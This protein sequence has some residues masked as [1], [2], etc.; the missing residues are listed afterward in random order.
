M[1][2]LNVID[3]AIVSSPVA[4]SG[5]KP[6]FI[7]RVHLKVSRVIRIIKLYITDKNNSRKYF[8]LSVWQ[9]H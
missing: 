7:K 1:N 6:P 3:K 5:W 4:N 8:I 2:Y 9:F